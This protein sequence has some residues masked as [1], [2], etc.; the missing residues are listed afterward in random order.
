MPFVEVEVVS[1]EVGEQHGGPGAP[2]VGGLAHRA[3]PPRFRGSGGGLLPPNPKISIKI[4]A[5]SLRSRATEPP[6][7]SSKEARAECL[8]PLEGDASEAEAE[9]SAERRRSVTA[10]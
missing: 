1:G 6:S 9:G 4:E 10:I 3:E 5:F 7:S 8:K 2:P